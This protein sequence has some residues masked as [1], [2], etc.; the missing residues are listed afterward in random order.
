MLKGKYTSLT[1]ESLF[2]KNVGSYVWH[3][4][5]FVSP[6]VWSGTLK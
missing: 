2:D 6:S 5:N 3:S 1:Q 4:K